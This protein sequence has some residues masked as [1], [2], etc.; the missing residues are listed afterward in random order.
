MGG[1]G[2]GGVGRW[3]V[4]DSWGRCWLL[5]P[6]GKEGEGG[7]SGRGHV[8]QLSLCPVWVQVPA[9]G[10]VSCVLCGLVVESSWMRGLVSY[11]QVGVNVGPRTCGLTARGSGG[12]RRSTAGGQTFPPV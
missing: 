11:P 7:G 4:P 12:F 6:L 2:G 1:V 5:G 10:V 3:E 9:L 8:R